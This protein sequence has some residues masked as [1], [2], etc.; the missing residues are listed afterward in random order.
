MPDLARPHATR[1][2]PTRPC[3]TSPDLFGSAF[4]MWDLPPTNGRITAAE[5]APCLTGP[6][7]TGPFHAGPY[8]TALWL[9]VFRWACHQLAALR[10]LSPSHTLPDQA[11]PDRAIPYLAGPVCLCVSHAGVGTR[12]CS[13]YWERKLPLTMP[14]LTVPDRAS[15]DRTSPDP[16]EPCLATFASVFTRAW[17]R[18]LSQATLR[19]LSLP[20]HLAVPHRTPPGLT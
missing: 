18:L 6:R 10:G 8:L 7:R 4:L 19:Q 5:A 9:C 2:S 13:H 1:P 12:R 15:P 3:Q 16:A 17:H 11:K 20:P 14:Y